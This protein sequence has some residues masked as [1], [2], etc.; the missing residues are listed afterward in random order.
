V[1]AIKVLLAALRIHI[2]KE[3]RKTKKRK[4]KAFLQVGN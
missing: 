4:K 1:R 3:E 2:S